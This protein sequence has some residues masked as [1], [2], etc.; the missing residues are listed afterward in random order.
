MGHPGPAC[1]GIVN[2]DDVVMSSNDLCLGFWEYA[3]QSG[4]LDDLPARADV[5]EIG[6]A[7]ADWAGPAKV[8]H[9]DWVSWGID[10]REPSSDAH[11]M[12]IRGDVLETDFPP[13]MFDLIVMVSTLEHIGIGHYGDT[14]CASGDTDTIA[15][16]AR[17]LRPGGYLYFDVPFRPEGPY[18]ETENYRAYDPDH[19]RSRLRHERLDE[20]WRTVIHTA[21]AD[22][23][24][25]AA[26]FKKTEGD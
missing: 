11:D 24:F 6:C 18:T 5:L 14:V 23:P 10:V 19:Y 12:V 13:R 15:R 26:I 20:V 1:G 22:G 8:Q 4:V 9:P 16:C 25:R 3:Q 21:H 2:D 7:E 17:W